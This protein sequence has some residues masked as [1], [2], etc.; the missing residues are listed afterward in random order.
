MIYNNGMELNK[1]AGG[2]RIHD[3]EAF[4]FSEKKVQGALVGKNGKDLYVLSP[5]RFKLF[6]EGRERLDI[7]EGEGFIKWKRGEIPFAAGDAFEADG[8]GEYEVN[9]GCAFTLTREQQS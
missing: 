8:A 2:A 7:L 3:K 9:G 4:C 6:A 1:I 5:R